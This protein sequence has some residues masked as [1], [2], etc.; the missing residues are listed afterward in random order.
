MKKKT[1]IRKTVNSKK[2]LADTEIQMVQ[3]MHTHIC[4][5][6]NTYMLVFYT[7]THTHTYINLFRPI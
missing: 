3:Y 7:H 2:I 1:E 5:C 4:T 6:I